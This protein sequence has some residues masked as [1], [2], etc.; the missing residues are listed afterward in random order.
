MQQN[1]KFLHC[2][3][4]KLF[5]FNFIAQSFFII[6][7]IKSS[8]RSEQDVFF[9]KMSRK[10]WINIVTS[11]GPVRTSQ[12]SEYGSELQYS[13]FGCFYPSTM[14]VYIW[15]WPVMFIPHCIGI[16]IRLQFLVNKTWIFLSDIVHVY[17]WWSVFIESLYATW[18]EE[19]S[20]IFLWTV[21]RTGRI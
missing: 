6:C 8:T 12:N 4:D 10:T 20:G 13:D 21:S 19:F 9:R 5:L 16:F 14:D 1:R 2:V 17:G 11:V 7:A 3:Q 18:I 15:S